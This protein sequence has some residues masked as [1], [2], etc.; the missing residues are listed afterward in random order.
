MKLISWLTAYDVEAVHDLF[1]EP[2]DE[3]LATQIRESLDTDAELPP[4]PAPTAPQTVDANYA[5]TVAAVLLSF[6]RSLP[7]SLVPFPLH[8]RCAEITSRDEA[9]EMLSVFPPASANVW[10]SVTALLHLL[11]LKDQTQA[12]A[13][14]ERQEK[15][16]SAS[17]EDARLPNTPS[18]AEILASIFAPVLLRDDID[19][20][21]P[22][23]ILGKQRFLLFF[24]GNE[25]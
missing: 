19:A 12:E 25:S 17:L 4:C 23:S 10:I 20:S 15:R 14:D 21:P 2:G 11:G 8:Q 18:R 24:M 3:N 1:I 22:I 7:E 9:L 16:L 6:L 13:P 5:R